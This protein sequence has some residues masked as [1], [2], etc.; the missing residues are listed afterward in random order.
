M[1]MRHDSL[2]R[3][4]G[5][6]LLFCFA[7]LV[8]LRADSSAPRTI[9]SHVGGAASIHFS[10]D[11]KFLVSGGG[12]K[13]I[14]VW[15]VADEKIVHEWA[16]PSAFTCAV[17]FSPDGK[18]VAAAGYGAGDANII[19]LYDVETGKPLPFATGAPLRGRSSPRLRP[20]W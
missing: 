11:G 1:H 2:A 12:D 6:A 5:L 18:T 15:N 9:G 14:R 13:T 20:R 16:G 3:T 7:P 4:A 17:R 10:P 19:H 8:A